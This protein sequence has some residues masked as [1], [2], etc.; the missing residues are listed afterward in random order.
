MRNSG[1]PIRIKYEC[2]GQLYLEGGLA[3]RKLTVIFTWDEIGAAISIG[4][5]NIDMVLTVEADPI[6]SRIV[7]ET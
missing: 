7:K 3:P 5:P 2:E 6:V 1:N 4:D